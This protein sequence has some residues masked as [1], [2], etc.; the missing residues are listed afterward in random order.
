MPPASKLK[1]IHLSNLGGWLK[2]AKRI[3][4]HFSPQKKGKKRKI[5]EDK[6]DSDELPLLEV[7]SKIDDPFSVTA[8]DNETVTHSEPEDCFFSSFSL[9][10]SQGLDGPTQG[11][12]HSFHLPPPPPPRSLF[13]PHETDNISILDHIS[14]GAPFP[15]SA[16]NNNQAK[17]MDEATDTESITDCSVESSGGVCFGPEYC[18]GKGRIAPTVEAASAA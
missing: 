17:T 8:S 7:I 10:N 6:A 13:I 1:N 15:L 12:F 9:D 2:G 5:N 16:Y 3:L 14:T 18:P 4:E 11:S